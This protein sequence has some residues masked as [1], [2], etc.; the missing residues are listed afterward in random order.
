[1]AFDAP[2][3]HRDSGLTWVHDPGLRT[4]ATAYID[5]S[6]LTVSV[7]YSMDM[8]PQIT[9][10]VHD[11]GFTYAMDNFFW[12]TRDVWY[13]SYAVMQF[14][15]PLFQGSDSYRTQVFEIGRS[16][17]GPSPGAGAVWSCE[18][19]T[20][21]IQQMKRDRGDESTPSGIVGKIP[22][23]GHEFAINVAERY[24][25]QSFI[26]E[27][28][29][30]KVITEFEPG[31]E[32]REGSSVWEVLD[33]LAKSAHFVCFEADGILFFASHAY[34]LGRWG[35]QT[36]MVSVTNTE[37]NLKETRQ[38]RFVACQWPRNPN[39]AIQLVA[40]PSVAKSDNDPFEVTGSMVVDRLNGTSLRPGMTIQLRGIPMFGPYTG[41]DGQLVEDD[42]GLYLIT[43]V[44]YDHLGTD[45][46]KITFRSPERRR[47]YVK[48]LGA[49]VRK[50]EPMRSANALSG[51]LGI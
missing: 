31:E 32:G 40:M 7:S 49:G 25:L 9:V 22:G 37:T 2:H 50:T 46:V 1:M 29:K 27:T 51:R 26:E 33:S 13:R 47:Q 4:E 11:P 42:S 20:K 5:S 19:R 41:A 12:I 16:N 39:D 8:C 48:Q 24:G 14:N 23:E 43:N 18:L 28:D 10:T 45:P 17:L 30:T 36:A 35:E 34:L 21:V 38:I 3:V 44:D 6:I 15:D